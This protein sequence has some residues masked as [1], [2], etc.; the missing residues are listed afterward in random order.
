MLCITCGS[1][2]SRVI[3]S[4]SSDDGKAIRRRRICQECGYRFTTYESQKETPLIVLKSDKSSETFDRDKLL[5]GL[6]TATI[7]RDI[8][9]A[10]LNELIDDVEQELRA[11][12]RN[13]VRSK[14]LGD[15]VLERLRELDDV[16]YIRFASVYKDFQDIDEFQAALKGMS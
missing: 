15:M 7:K 10:R 16:A 1:D 8:P 6:M 14:V 4:R 2:N 12:P 3:D 9:V 13:E 5:R 11:A